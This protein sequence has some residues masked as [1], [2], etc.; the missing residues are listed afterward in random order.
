[1]I[2]TY[3]LFPLYSSNV[4]IYQYETSFVRIITVDKKTQG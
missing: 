3:T 2:E 1:M 4:E